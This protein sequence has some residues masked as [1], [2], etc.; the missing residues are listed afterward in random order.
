MFV[1]CIG[2][3]SGSKYQTFAN[4][5]E[6]VACLGITP[7]ERHVFEYKNGSKA[8]IRPVGRCYM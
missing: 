7:S 3:K 5:D 2:E 4:F 1:H 8:Y 6:N